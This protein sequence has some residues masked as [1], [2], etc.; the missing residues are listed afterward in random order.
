MCN[1]TLQIDRLIKKPIKQHVQLIF[2]HFNR[3]NSAIEKLCISKRDDVMDASCGEG[4]G[5]FILSLKAKKVFGLDINRNYL[6]IA[7]KIFNQENIYFYRYDEFD[8]LLN[9]KRVRRIEKIVCIETFE[10]IPKLEI[11]N[12]MRRLLSYLKKGGHIFLTTALGCNRP[13]TYNKFHLNEP[14][15]NFI[16]NTFKPLFKKITFDLGTFKNSFGYD[17]KYCHALLNDFIGDYNAL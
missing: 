3:Y 2:N 9:E 1:E 5:S 14:S 6:K 17:A 16:H 12:F 8:K 15:I 11:Q 10:H 7:K 13:S 4:Y